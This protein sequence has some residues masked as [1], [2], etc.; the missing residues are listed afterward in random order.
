MINLYDF[1]L[2]GNCYKVRL[3]LALLGVGY[4]SKPMNLKEQEHKSASFLKLN[5][6]GQ[7]PVLSDG[8]VT[9]R[10]SQAILV[11]LA[12]Q[13]GNETWLPLEA[14]K[15]A[16]VNSW[17]SVAANEVFRGPALLRLH[18][19]FG[20]AIDVEASQ[21]ITA[22]LLSILQTRLSDRH[23]LTCGHLTIADIAVYPYI[24]L[25]PEGHIDLSPYP[26]ILAWLARIQ[27]LP[28]YVEM[29]G[30]WQAGAVN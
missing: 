27:A 5:P 12:R 21:Q 28:N 25:A 20:R 24:A 17:L 10:D 19:K 2:S 3:M 6:F 30:M 8:E 22:N 4:D 11:Y 13:Y 14:A 16:D 1:A 26:A 29:P 15:L 18:H 7:V 9:L 23:W